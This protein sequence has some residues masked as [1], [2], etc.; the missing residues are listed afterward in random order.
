MPQLPKC[1][2]A[3]M[4]NTKHIENTTHRG[5]AQ[6]EYIN[7][8][9]YYHSCKNYLTYRAGCKTKKDIKH[10]KNKRK[11]NIKSMTY[12]FLAVLFE[13]RVKRSSFWPKILL[14]CLSLWLSIA[15]ACKTYF[16]TP[17]IPFFILMCPHKVT[18]CSGLHTPSLLLPR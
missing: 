5:Y 10:T 16:M 17:L 11:L 7:V 14:V 12:K 8:V 1:Q 2:N 4:E 15:L 18:S 13:T 9:F 3:M 6:H